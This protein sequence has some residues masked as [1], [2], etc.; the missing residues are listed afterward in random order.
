MLCTPST[1]LHTK[2]TNKVEHVFE[3]KTKFLML[4]FIFTDKICQK[5]NVCI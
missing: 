4:D 1:Q 3:R 5:E 2:R